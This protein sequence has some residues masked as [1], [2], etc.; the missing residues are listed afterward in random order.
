M[1]QKITF[2]RLACQKVRTSFPRSWQANVSAWDGVELQ[3]VR[4]DSPDIENSL[5]YFTRVR[6]HITFDLLFDWFEFNHTSKSVVN[7]TR[8]LNIKNCKIWSS[9]QGYL[10]EK[11]KKFSDYCNHFISVDGKYVQNTHIQ[12]LCKDKIFY[13]P[14][15]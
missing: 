1:Q 11:C 10:I 14:S 15:F 2:F 13:Y 12:T 7:S 4:F 9:V 6:Q 8:D 3:Q 5:R